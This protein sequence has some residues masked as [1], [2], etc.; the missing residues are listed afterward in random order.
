VEGK[1]NEVLLRFVA[2]ELG[3]RLTEVKLVRGD[4]SREKTLHVPE[5]VDPR[6]LLT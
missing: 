5:R 2:A 4:T 3:L 1:A 6:T